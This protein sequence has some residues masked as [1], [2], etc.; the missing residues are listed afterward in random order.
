LRK[1]HR[2]DAVLCKPAPK[3]RDFTEEEFWLFEKAIRQGE[4]LGHV[5]APMA[6]VQFF[7]ALRISEVAAIHFEDINLNRKEPQES[8]LRICRHLIYLR[9]RGRA[10]MLADGFKNAGGGVNS[11]KEQPVFQQTY[12]A[13]KDVFRIGTGLI[14]TNPD[15]SP[16]TYRQIQKAYDLAF[17][18]AKLP[19]RGT[20]VLRH[21]GCRRVYNAT[22]DLAL[23][24]MLL[25]NADMDSTLVYA[26]RDKGAFKDYAKLTWKPAAENC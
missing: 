9:Q 1:R 18:R 22:K 17:K 25:G 10:P 13:I 8:T 20:H 23:A 4:K 2:Q 15:G 19:Y 12:E 6:T 14:F 11:V 26:K 7:Q 3:H 24:Q 21:G 5:L 16:L